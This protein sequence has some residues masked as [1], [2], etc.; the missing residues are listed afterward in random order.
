MSKEL[1]VQI[2]ASRL[3]H[4]A[5]TDEEGCTY[6]SGG[7]VRC[8]SVDA[9]LEASGWE[10]FRGWI[11]IEGIPPVKILKFP[12]VFEE[13]WGWDRLLP[14]DLVL[15]DPSDLPMY[16]SYLE[17]FYNLNSGAASD[18][19]NSKAAADAAL[20][21][22]E[23]EKDLCSEWKIKRAKAISFDESWSN[24][25]QKCMSDI[26]DDAGSES[27]RPFATYAAAVCSYL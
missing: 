17:Q 16:E 1:G 12:V 18:H 10:E 21:C 24:C 6:I 23:K 9:P 27:R 20:K 25:V 14:Y 11:D 3:G 22:L 8:K 26:V 2:E 19:Y 15:E 13:L 5:I 4:L 7:A